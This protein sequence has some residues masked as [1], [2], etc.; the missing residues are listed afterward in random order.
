VKTHGLQERESKCAGG[1]AAC[2]ARPLA[3]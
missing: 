3:F 1:P 2:S